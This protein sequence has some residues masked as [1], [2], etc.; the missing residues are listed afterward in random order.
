[1][2]DAAGG[3][4][5][6][7]QHVVDARQRQVGPE[8]R[9]GIGGLASCCSA[10]EMAARGS[11]CMAASNAAKLCGLTVEAAAMAWTPRAAPPRDNTTQAAKRQHDSFGAFITRVFGCPNPG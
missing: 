7:L 1:L 10:C 9:T 8:A 3:V 2:L 11:S 5:L 4:R 6:P